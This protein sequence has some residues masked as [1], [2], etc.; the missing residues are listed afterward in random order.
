MPEP[1]RGQRIAANWEAVVKTKPE[2]QIHDDY[3]L[4]NQLSQGEGF[5]GISGGD[6][7]SGPIEYAL[8][9]TVGSYSDTDTISITRVDVFD[10]YE[11][12][13]KEYAG[14]YVISE[15]EEDRNEGAG[16]VFPLRAAKLENLKNSLRADLN[17]DM[18]ADGTGNSGKDLDGLGNLVASTPTSGTVG[19]INRANFSFW[20][21]QQTAG[22]QSA[23]AY[24][25]LR[26]AMRSIY[27]LCSNGVADA[28]PTF[29][30]TT[31]TVFEA[32]EGLLL[33]N[34]RFSS[35][36]EGDGGFKNEVIKFKGAKL[37]YDN[38][39]TAAELRF[40][41]PKFIKLVYKTGAWM[42]MRPAVQ[43]ANQT[44]DVVLVRTMCNL[45][46]TQPRRLGVVTAIT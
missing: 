41:N 16:Q 34:E 21:N 39:A 31:R 44:I 37:S 18:H 43:P 26:A 32:Y 46:A 4:L 27:N 23:A 40:L 30:V 11:Y 28:H 6:F 8:N 45:I 10:R 29:G 1:N 25:N 14:S 38:D 5:L 42:K 33:A 15:L 13:W 36:S 19:G 12:N 35:K 22:T 20:R 17:V 2:D 24:D 3:W 9:A 7:I